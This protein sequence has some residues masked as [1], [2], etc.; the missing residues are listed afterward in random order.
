M[1]KIFASLVFKTFSSYIYYYYYYY[2][3]IIRSWNICSITYVRKIVSIALN[4]FKERDS[5]CRKQYISC[6]YWHFKLISP[7]PLPLFNLS[8]YRLIP[9]CLTWPYSFLSFL[10]LVEEEPWKF[11]GQ[12]DF[13]LK[14]RTELPSAKYRINHDDMDFKS[15]SRSLRCC[16]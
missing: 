6:L 8:C 12:R 2:V 5:I 14:I 15:L 1:A 4:N 10:L 7:S 16:R 3:D 9:V 13:F 11:P